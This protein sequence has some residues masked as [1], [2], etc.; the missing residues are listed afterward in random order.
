MT[1]IR[2]DSL[3]ADERRHLAATVQ[4]LAELSR[5]LDGGFAT[6]EVRH[7]LL[8]AGRD[9]PLEALAR[10]GETL[11]LKVWPRRMTVG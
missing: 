8:A 4:L 2:S 6:A 10:A 3:P 1:T 5:T 9:E 7:A 11:G